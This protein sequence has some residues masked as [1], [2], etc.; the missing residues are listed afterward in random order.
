MNSKVESRSLLQKIFGKKSYIV[1]G[2]TIV[3]PRSKTPLIVL[4]CLAV[5]IFFWQ[6]IPTKNLTLKFDQ[7]TVLIKKM[8]DPSSGKSQTWDGWFSYMWELRR[9]VGETLKM[10][11]IGTLAGAVIALPFSIIAA[12]NVSRKVWLYQPVRLFVNFIRTIP[13]VVLAVVAMFFCGLGALPGIVSITIFSFGL[14]TKMLYEIIETVDMGPFEA[15]EANG[16]NKLQAFK[17]AIV[18]QLLPVF[19]GYFIYTFEINVRASVILGYVGAGGIGAELDNA[20]SNMY[21]D[22]VG[23]VVV[24]LFFLVL[25]IQGLTSY[26]RGKLA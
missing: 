8:F 7:L 23:A 18:P 25:I 1:N 13:T 15:L 16:A 26:I 3:K 4:I 6:F 5:F 12:Q 22:H 2:K 21:Y 14:L 24:V 19:L 11:L 20:M 17:M 9:S 10:V